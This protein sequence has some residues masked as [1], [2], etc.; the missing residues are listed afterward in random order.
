MT[1]NDD[2]LPEW[3]RPIL[4]A[5]IDV[6]RDLGPGLLE[7]AYQ[8]CLAHELQLRG[9]SFDRE[10]PLPIVY[11]GLEL[12]CGYRLDFLVQQRVIVEIKAVDTVLPIHLAQLL[13][14]LRL[15]RVAIGLIIN[16]NRKLL[17]EGVRRVI[18]H[19]LLGA[20]DDLT[21]SS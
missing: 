16:F 11:K 1:T 7:S 4:A 13:T 15:K 9:I 6:H 12:E 21:H 17:M 5:A 8:A 10:V 14:Y 18:N 2:I 20:I 19:E 3:T